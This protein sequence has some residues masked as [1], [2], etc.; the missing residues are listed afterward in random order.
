[1]ISHYESSYDRNGISC[2][3]NLQCSSE[4]KY[5]CAGIYLCASL[6]MVFS[7]EK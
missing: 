4:K 7:Y 5:T 2:T 3:P 6:Y 1:M